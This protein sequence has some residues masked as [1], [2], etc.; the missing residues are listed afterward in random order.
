M[1]SPTVP[2][3]SARTGSVSPMTPNA[4]GFDGRS[5]RATQAEKGPL[6]ALRGPTRR[7]AVDVGVPDSRGV[8]GV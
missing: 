7:E 6:L 5:Q 8:Q 2:S 4:S 1:S 3:T